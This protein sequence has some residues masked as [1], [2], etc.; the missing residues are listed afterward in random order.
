MNGNFF[1]G[2]F[3]R[4]VFVF[5]PTLLLALVLVVMISCVTMY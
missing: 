2:V 4:H 5:D 3:Q 1:R